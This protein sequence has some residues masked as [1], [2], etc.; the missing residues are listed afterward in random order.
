MKNKMVWMISAAFLLSSVLSSNAYA[1]SWWRTFKNDSDT[2]WEIDVNSVNGNVY[3]CSPDRNN[4]KISCKNCSVILAPKM[5][6]EIKYTTTDNENQ[7]KFGFH[8]PGVDPVPSG[9]QCYNEFAVGNGDEPEIKPGG[10]HGGVLIN[11]SSN[12]YITF[13]GNDAAESGGIECGTFG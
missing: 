2:T 4:C 12:S 9:T 3:F 1:D 7:T 5:Q 8:R 6:Y 10:Q 11:G 13:T